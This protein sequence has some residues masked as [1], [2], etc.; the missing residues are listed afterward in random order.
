[1]LQGRG[2]LVLELLAVDGLAASSSARWITRLDHEVRDD[3][4]EDYAVVVAAAG[5]GLEVLACLCGVRVS[6]CG[7]SS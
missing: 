6:L 7:R 2:D 4:V 3:A 1:M 5:E